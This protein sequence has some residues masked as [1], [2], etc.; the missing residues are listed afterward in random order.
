[1]GTSTTGFA[2][3]VKSSSAGLKDPIITNV[4]IPLAN[5]EYSVALPLGTRQFSLRNMNKYNVK[6][7]FTPGTSGTTYLS[8]LPWVYEAHGEIEDTVTIYFQSTST[9]AQFDI[10]SWS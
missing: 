3:R 9:A 10:L 5:T 7:S 8:L 6:Y 1:M 2:T 4:I